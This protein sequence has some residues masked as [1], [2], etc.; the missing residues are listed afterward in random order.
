[1]PAALTRRAAATSPG[2]DVT[3][4]CLSKRSA[5]DTSA[6]T[7]QRL[8][9][10]LFRLL[11]SALHAEPPCANPPST[12]MSWRDV[13]ALVLRLPVYTRSGSVIGRTQQK[14]SPIGLSL[15]PPCRHCLRDI[16]D[17][18][19]MSLIRG[20]MFQRMTSIH[21]RQ[22]ARRVPLAPVA[23]ISLP[24]ITTCRLCSTA[25]DADHH[26]ADTIMPRSASGE[27]R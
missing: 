23:H 9:V 13:H 1:M 5:H 14:H 16:L 8:F 10:C 12:T 26:A 11:P 6:A 25:Q 3:R 24:D 21:Q 17:C 22:D 19:A 15:P 18:R 20:E 4:R 2:E 7:H 27:L